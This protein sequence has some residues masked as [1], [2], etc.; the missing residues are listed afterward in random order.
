MFEAG[1]INPCVGGSNP[2]SA[3]ND[4]TTRGREQVGPREDR[5][6]SR[7]V[8]DR[9][10][11]FRGRDGYA[12]NEFSQR[13]GNSFVARDS[14]SR[15]RCCEVIHD[16]KVAFYGSRVQGHDVRR[17]LHGREFV[18]QRLAFFP[19]RSEARTGFLFRGDAFDIAVEGAI[20]FALYLAQPGFLAVPLG[21][22]GRGEPPALLSVGFEET[23]DSP[24]VLQLGLQASEYATLD[25][26]KVEGPCVGTTAA[27]AHACAVD[28]PAFRIAVFHNE[29]SATAAA[30]Q[31]AGQEMPRPAWRCGPF[32]SALVET[33]LYGGEYIRI[34]DA[35]LRNRRYLPT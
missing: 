17:R 7:Y 11:F 24:G 14:A 23:L 19:Q 8:Y 5:E 27:F 12:R 31:Q 25:L 1:E 22:F 34:D 18:F 32:V 13:V 4:L 2:P 26:I 33:R 9:R 6:T 28:A 35:Q 16:C 29:G 30:T 21:L 3:T 20:E 15:E 10:A